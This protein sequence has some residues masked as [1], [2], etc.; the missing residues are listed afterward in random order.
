MDAELHD[1]GPTLKESPSARLSDLGSRSNIKDECCDVKSEKISKVV[2]GKPTDAAGKSD[3][4]AVW[5][6]NKEP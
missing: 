2:N 1:K 5:R 4:D 6:I 3:V